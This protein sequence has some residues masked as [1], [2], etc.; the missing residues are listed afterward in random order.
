MAGGHATFRPLS[1]K[2]SHRQALLRNILESVIEHESIQTTWHK[3]KEGQRLVEKAITLG[4][5]NT[6]ASRRKATALFFRPSLLPKLFGTLATRYAERPGGYTRVLRIEPIKED[7][8]ASAILELVDGPKDIRWAM[9][10]RTIAAERREGKPTREITQKNI[11]KVTR[12]RKHGMEELEQLASKFEQEI[13]PKKEDR[14]VR[15][16][17]KKVVY[18]LAR[19]LMDKPKKAKWTR[20]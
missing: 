17:P 6:E 1:R 16:P 3:A 8:A 15:V 7:Q 11:D 20:N 10:A 13:D 19:H 12:Y 18:P 9:T 4:K 2:S 14:R 5:K